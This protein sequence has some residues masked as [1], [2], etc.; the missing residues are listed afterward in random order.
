[1]TSSLWIPLALLTLLSW[2][3]VGVF[4]KLA[5]ERIGVQMA[6]LWAVFG[7]LLLQ[8]FVF[9]TESLLAYSAKSLV[10]AVL[11]GICN[12]LGILCLMAAMQHGGKASIVESLSALYPVLVVILS[13]LLLNERLSAFHLIGI[14]C[15]VLAGSFLS[16]E[17]QISKNS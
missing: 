13:P 6:L 7:F 4:Q 11:N 8:P 14:G 2:G 1:M 3:V 12:G 9:P 10:C 16:A 17:T 5:V 15:A